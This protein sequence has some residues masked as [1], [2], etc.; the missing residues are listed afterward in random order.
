MDIGAI[1]L[2]YW[3]DVQSILEAGWLD[4]AIL[5]D[6][7]QMAHPLD[8][9]LVSCPGQ[10]AMLQA[11]GIGKGKA[12]ISPLDRREL[13]IEALALPVDISWLEGAKGLAIHLAHPL[14]ALAG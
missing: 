13:L 7:L 4:H 2:A 9:Y 3:Q 6:K 11:D 10:R 14:L 8:L 5:E 12:W 1:L